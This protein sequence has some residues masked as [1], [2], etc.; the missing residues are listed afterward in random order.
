M[1][2][3]AYG[4]YRG[5]CDVCGNITEDFDTHQ[6]CVNWIKENWKDKYDRKTQRWEHFCEC[7]SKRK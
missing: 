6:D 7:C 5:V 2:D 4:K 3:K 1:I